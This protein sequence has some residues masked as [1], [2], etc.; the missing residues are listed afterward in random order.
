MAKVFHRRDAC[1]PFFA[2]RAYLLFISEIW[3]H[4]KLSPVVLRLTM[5]VRPLI[6]M[7]AVSA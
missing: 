5:S 3:Y 7:N 1:A 2:A 4:S 6:W